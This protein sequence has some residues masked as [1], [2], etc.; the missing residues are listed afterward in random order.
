M[1]CKLWLLI[2][3]KALSDNWN[4]VASKEG[5]KDERVKEG[6]GEHHICW[7]VGDISSSVYLGQD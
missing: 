2:V 4:V 3:G 6:K 7:D 5:R 1:I